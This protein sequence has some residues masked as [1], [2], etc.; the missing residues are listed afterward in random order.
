MGKFNYFRSMSRCQVFR[1][2]LGSVRAIFSCFKCCTKWQKKSKTYKL[3][4]HRNC[5]GELVVCGS[6][7][8]LRNVKA[9]DGIRMAAYME[10]YTKKTASSIE[11]K[12]SDRLM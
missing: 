1:W 9:V 5:Y 6:T 4:H 12:D 7:K 3:V 2:H 10:Q 8:R 11:P